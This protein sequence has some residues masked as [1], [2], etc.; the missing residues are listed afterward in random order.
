MTGLD[1]TQERRI[2]IA[3]NDR[4]REL[5]GLND[6]H[7]R[8]IEEGFDVTI[9][10]RGNEVIIKGQEDEVGRVVRLFNRLTAI[11]ERGGRVTERDV[12]YACDWPGRG[13]RSP[14]PTRSR[15]SSSRR[16]GESRSGPRP[17]GRRS[18]LT[19]SGAVA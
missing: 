2:L 18:T 15:T 17:S 5:F 14:L 7:L 19:R 3:D 11:Q 1:E 10:P 16:T 13:T 4:A 9:V 6:S 12:R 8:F